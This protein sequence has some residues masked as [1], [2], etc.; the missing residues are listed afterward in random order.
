M[1]YNEFCF[2]SVKNPAMIWRQSPHWRLIRRRPGNFSLQLKFAGRPG[3]PERFYSSGGIP[4]DTVIRNL[5]EKKRRRD[6][7][8]SVRPPRDSPRM[9]ARRS[10]GVYKGKLARQRLADS[11]P[12]ACRSPLDH[13]AVFPQVIVRGSV[14]SPPGSLT[15]V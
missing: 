7:P 8:L 4:R 11:G 13:R 3:M 14:D 10:S 2:P 5:A 15:A 6:R 1:I 9:I 12:I